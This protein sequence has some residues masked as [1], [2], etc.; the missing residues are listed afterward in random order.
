MRAKSNGNNRNVNSKTNVQ[1]KKEKQTISLENQIADVQLVSELRYS[2]YPHK[3][4]VFGVFFKQ[5]SIFFRLF[6]VY[7]LV[8]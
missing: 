1:L 7:S 3:Q 6:L 2:H 4:D 8:H 5:I